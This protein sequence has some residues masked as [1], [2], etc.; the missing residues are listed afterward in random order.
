MFPAAFT[1][2]WLFTYLGEKNWLL[3]II[4]AND[5]MITLIVIEFLIFGIGLSL[6]IWGVYLIARSRLKNT[7]LVKTGPYKY[8]RHPQHLGIILMSLSISLYIP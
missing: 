1:S 6:F 2:W 4:S 7:G 8:I 3:G 5:N